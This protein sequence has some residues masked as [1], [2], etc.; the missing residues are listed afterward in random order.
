MVEFRILGALEAVAGREELSL[1]SVQQR[2]VLALLLVR[3]PEPVSRDRLIDELWGERPPATAAHAVQVY[4]SGIRKALRPAGDAVAVRSSPAGYVLEVEDERV[5]ARRFERLIEDA[6]RLG[7]DPAGARELFERALGLWRSRPLAE[8]EQ[9]EL[10]RREADRL[11]ELQA[12]GLEGLVEARLACGEHGEVIGTLTGLV[13]ANPLRE[14]PRRLL[15]LALYRSGRHAEALAA[16]RDACAALD[17]IG[18][19]PGPELR[20]L[21]AAILR[22]DPSLG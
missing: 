14:R 15:M 9:F 6:Q 17:E 7:E 12:V 11:E 16:Y 22:H 21:E 20:Q 4:V 18:L 1:G 13:A 5:D 2:A 10:A 3:A 8:F 19:Q